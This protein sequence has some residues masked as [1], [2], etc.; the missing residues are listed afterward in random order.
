[1]AE[2]AQVHLEKAICI[3]KMQHQYIQNLQKANLFL[4]AKVKELQE[5]KN[6]EKRPAA[7][8]D[9][10]KGGEKGKEN[11][12]EFEL[13]PIGRIEQLNKKEMVEHRIDQQENRYANDRNNGNGG[14]PPRNNFNNRE[15]GGQGRGYIPNNGRGGMDTGFGGGRGTFNEGRGGRGGSGGYNNGRGGY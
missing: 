6:E 13:I 9:E 14:G 8:E 4:K 10:K 15:F 12:S 3:N 1:M 7:K 11:V 2:G 5:V